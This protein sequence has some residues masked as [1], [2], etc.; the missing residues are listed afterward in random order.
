M[1]AALPTAPGPTLSSWPK[2]IFPRQEA[3]AY[4][5]VVVRN[6]SSNSWRKRRKNTLRQDR[7]RITSEL[8]R[9]RLAPW[10]KVRLMLWNRIVRRQKWTHRLMA[11]S[12]APVVFMCAPYR[13]TSRLGNEQSHSPLGFGNDPHC[14]RD[15]RIADQR[16]LAR[17]RRGLLRES[18]A[19][20]GPSM[21]LPERSSADRAPKPRG[22]QS[23]LRTCTSSGSSSNSSANG[24]AMGR[25]PR[26]R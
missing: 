26:L 14:C 11:Q 18:R 25:K 2:A 7:R 10:W 3:A 20:P 23:T 6:V 12:V 1:K 17:S 16:P 8:S 4:F 13:L 24:S 21:P 5:G 15:G 19:E 22:A 9:I